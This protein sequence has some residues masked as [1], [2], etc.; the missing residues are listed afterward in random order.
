MPE[1]FGCCVVSIFQ[2]LKQCTILLKRHGIGA[3]WELD[4][5]VFGLHLRLACQTGS[6]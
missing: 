6:Y 5:F 1:K 2:H 3:V 4:A